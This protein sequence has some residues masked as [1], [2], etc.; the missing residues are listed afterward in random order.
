MIALVYLGVMVWFGDAIARRWL[1]FVSWPHRLA[2][3]FLVGLLLGTWTSYLAGLIASGSGDPMAVGAMA[4]TWAM[5]IAA[6]WLRRRAPSPAIAGRGVLRSSRADWLVLLAF[7]VLVGW[8]MTAT[9]S[10][11]DGQLKIAGDLWSD[12]GPT[13]AISQSFALGHNFPTQY[14]HFAGL[15]I[16]YHFLYYFQVG[17]LTYLGL[18]P[19]AANNILSIA[20]LV[21]ML[22][23]IAAL[24]ERLFG[25]RWVGWLGA[26]LFFF[27]G[28]LSFIPYLGSFPSIGDA[29]AA[30]PTLDHFLSSGFPY[31]GEEWG[32]WTQ[33][34]FLNQRHLPSAIGIV[35]LIVLFLLDRLRPPVARSVEGEDDR[36]PGPVAAVV[37]AVG[38]RRRQLTETMARPSAAIL[39][40]G[41]DPWLPGYALC[42]LLAGL[43]PL[44]NGAMFI[45]AAAVLGVMFVVFPN[46]SRMVVLAVA[47]AV[48]ALPQ[49]LF[50]RPGTMAG[51]QTY[52]SFYW[53]YVIDNPTLVRVATYLAFIFGPKLILASVALL[54]GTWEQRRVFL[55]FVS[56]AAVAFLVQLSVEVLAN[57]K[58]IN[59][60]LAVANLFVAYGLVRLWRARSEIRLPMRLV[61]VGLTA[62]IVAGGVID[63]IP[64]KNERI[65]SAGVAGDP[66]YDWVTAQT[67]PND[68]FLSDIYVVHG[69]LLA[70][71]KLYL[72]WTYYAWSAGYD[73]ATRES[74]YRDLF[75]LRSP[76]E[77]ASRLQAAGIDYVAFDDGLRDRGFAP[78]L[79][80]E[81]FR[82]YFEAVFTDPN[83]RYAHLTIY[84]VPPDPGA[85]AALPDAAP[86]DMYVGGQGSGPGQFDG[87]R[88]L[89]RDPSGD[90][91]I[92][93]SGN[94]RVS[95]Y[96]SSGDLIGSFEAPGSVG[97]PAGQPTGVA[98]DFHGQVYVAAG[99]RLLAFDPSGVFV[100]EWREADGR[101]FSALLDVA[102]DRGGRVFALD[103]GTGRVIEIQTDGTISAWGSI[104]D[105]D[106]E[107]RHPSGLAVNG[108]T[109]VVA[110][111]GNA[112]VE[113]F[114][115]DGTFLDSLPV[116]DWQGATSN[117]GAD[118]AIN[119][120]G[121]IWASSPATNSVVVFRPDGTLAG[122]L[123]PSGDDQLDRPSGLALE[124][125]GALFVSNLGSNR[126]TLLTQSNP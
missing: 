119:D 83:N 85:S 61:A 1:T 90:L 7:T 55:A 5:A 34:V 36:G 94:G 75:A 52:P 113:E 101:A 38:E 15:P 106:G 39:A 30:L 19:A 27:H 25:S 46:R 105:G 87:P 8:M 47:A 107:L 98:V 13:T 102:T 69:I 49:L 76:R 66:L 117:S 63:L 92:A 33:D 124:P 65:Y 59:T 53:G 11:A 118:V 44:Y 6:I 74:W 2:T 104:G 26:S 51:Q 43:L 122:S 37:A 108:D 22:V 42:G 10:L 17:N 89:A 9:F 86:E 120:A 72:G 79:N 110:D 125:G 112:R 116:P 21:A 97:E 3:A 31:R 82:S 57:H 60:W 123:T 115:R 73:T 50:L 96:S 88:G 14:P 58:F 68:V 28:A 20:S 41:R 93:D 64:I 121:T 109:V 62:A 100:K 48:P 126:I 4:S 56:L 84:R 32:I 103:A 23:V 35:L 71:R 114:D 16:R 70:G 29:L 18:D 99:N 80:E 77:V 24:G 45:A 91:L 111:A 12:F 54:T 81:L 95:R 78:R 40:F 67:R